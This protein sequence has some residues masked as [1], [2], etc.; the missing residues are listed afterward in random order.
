M[1]LCVCLSF[2]W[3]FIYEYNYSRRRGTC[4]HIIGN[5]TDADLNIIFKGQ[6]NIHSLTALLQID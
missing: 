3:L 4:S 2:L 6:I 1:C 5:I